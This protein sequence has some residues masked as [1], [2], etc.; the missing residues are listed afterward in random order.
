MMLWKCQLLICFMTVLPAVAQ[1][2]AAPDPQIG[3]INGT[4]LDVYGDIV[5]G[6][7]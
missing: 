5:P 4:V 1:D 6:A 7:L 2:I 3:N